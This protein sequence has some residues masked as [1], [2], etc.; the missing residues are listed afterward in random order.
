MANLQI[1]NNG[2]GKVQL[3]LNNFSNFVP[4][5]KIRSGFF[6][7]HKINFEK[8]HDTS[9]EKEKQQSAFDIETNGK[10]IFFGAYNGQEYKYVIIRK[11]ED[12]HTALNLLTEETY[13]YGD[14]DLPV[15]LANYVLLGKHSKFAKKIAGES[16]F[17]TDNFRIKRFK[18][19]YR[20][21]FG[22]RAIN[23]I[24]LLQFYSES[25]FEAYSR[26]YNKLKE[27]GFDVFDNQTLKEWKEDKEK[28]VNFDKLD[29]ND[30]QTIEEIARYNKLDVIATYQLALLKNSLFGIQVKTT[31]PRTAISYIISQ[32]QS[33]FVKGLKPYPEIELTLKRLYKGGLFDSNELGKFKKVY[34]YDVNSM[35]PYMMTWL[36]ELELVD[37]QKGFEV[38]E[39]PILR[40]TEF[41]EDVK[42]LYIYKIS[43][44]QSKKYVASK[45]N[46]M[47]LRMMYSRGSFFDFELADQKSEL[48]KDI[49]IV[50]EYYTMKFRITK[51][52]IFK[53]VIEDLYSKRLQLKK[54]KNPLEKVYKLILNSSYGKFGE[55]I[56]FNAKFQNVIYASMITALGR[57][58]I[59]NVDP[60]AISY[61]TDSVISKQPIKA[62][63]VGDQLGQLKMEGEGPAIVIGNGQ[64]ILED[65][66]EKMVK[67]RGFNVDEKLAEKIIEYIGNNLA[68]GKIIRVQIPTKI[69]VRNLQQFKVL[70]EKDSN[71]LMGLLTNQIKSFTPL[72]TKQRYIYNSYWYGEMFRDEIDHKE[73]TKS[74]R[75]YIETIEPI[76]L[77]TIIS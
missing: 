22:D 62:E 48:S 38:N 52:R 64:Y 4:S 49:K 8:E 71:V 1:L 53:D 31:L 68:K 11:P 73:Y 70:S 21:L 5:F 54:Q 6:T 14:Y 65:P 58:F 47:L 37:I 20:I 63:L 10:I 69:M 3:K 67:L 33:K 16:F 66:E 28:R 15:S 60:Y 12:V 32:V 72:N 59:Q 27:L 29:F 25:L 77:N 24:N 43:L 35:Y 57:T 30:K 75:K 42:Y 36:P 56:G 44:K 76:D 18:N 40:G 26:Y 13:F 19:F 2:K 39:E 50:G 9:Y 51:H 46:G 55:R 23:A 45:A 41:N 34:K 74:W 7:V 61:L 17:S